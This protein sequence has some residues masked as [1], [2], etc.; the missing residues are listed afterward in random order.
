MLEVG[1]E[2]EDA[3]EDGAEVEALRA[4]AES[5]AE[6]AA[7]TGDGDERKLSDLPA[8][9]VE[10]LTLQANGRAVEAWRELAIRAR[11][12]AD[13]ETKAAL[14][15]MDAHLTELDAILAGEPSEAAAAAAAL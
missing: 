9:Y 11:L 13:L 7:W 14:A 15:R 12:D 4:M 6:W 1:F 3:G 8:D 2:I 10:E 5:L